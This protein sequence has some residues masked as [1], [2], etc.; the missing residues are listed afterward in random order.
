MN[1]KILIGIL[2]IAG[3]IIGFVGGRTFASGEISQLTGRVT[4]LTDQATLTQNLENQLAETKAQLENLNVNALY[5]LIKIDGK[6]KAY[7]IGDLNQ[8]PPTIANDQIGGTPVI[9]SWCPLC[10]TLTAY[11]RMVDGQILTFKVDG[12]RKIP[13]TEIENLH[14]K[15]DQT[16]TVWAQGPGIAVEGP[17]KGT[18]LKSYSLQLFNQDVITKMGVDVW[19]P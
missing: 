7:K 4:Q 2:L 6:A 14:F 16:G 18:E 9:V 17:L 8:M 10:G 19:K 5:G 15:D 11:D 12:A 1:T 3:L 13:G